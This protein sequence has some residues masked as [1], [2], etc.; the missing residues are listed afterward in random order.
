MCSDV[1]LA[2]LGGDLKR[3]ELLSARL[4]DVHSELFIACSILKYH[5]SSP[6]SPAATAHASFALQRSLHHAQQALAAFCSNFPSPWLGGLLR[7]L[8]LPLFS[9][10]QA[11]DDS[12]VRELG[13]LIMEPNPVRETLA[14]MVH[15]SVDPEDAVGRLETTYQML[16]TVDEPW[17][18]FVRARSQGK[19]DKES[20]EDALKEAAAGNII[21]DADIELLLDYDAR[22]HDCLLTDHFP[23]QAR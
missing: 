6:R 9:K 13:E 12:Q 16:L 22:R 7:L 18:A 14:A 1:A 21:T 23:Q 3:R 15:L 19:L 5:E 8:C 17:Q 11:P 4:G 10:V 2:V 20:L